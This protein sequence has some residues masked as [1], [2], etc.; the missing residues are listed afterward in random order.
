MRINNPKLISVL[1]ALII[2]TLYIYSIISY[3]ERMDVANQKIITQHAHIISDDIWRFDK[4]SAEKYLKLA[5]EANYYKNIIVTLTNSKKYLGIDTIPNHTLEKVLIRHS[6]IQTK[7]YSA[8]I[9]AGNFNIGTLS[10]TVYIRNIYY[11]FNSFLVCTTLFLIFA[12]IIYLQSSKRIL[13]RTVLDRTAELQDKEEDLRTTINSIGDAL[14]STDVTGSIN[15][16]NPVTLILLDSSNEDLLGQSI[17]DKLTLYDYNLKTKISLDVPSIIENKQID[18]IN[19]IACLSHSDH[20]PIVRVSASYVYNHNICTGLVIVIS[21]ITETKN[22][23]HKLIQSQRMESI[24]LMAGGVAHDLN[25]ILSGIVGYPELILIDLPKDSELRKPIEAIMESGKRAATVVADL[26]TVARGAASTRNIHNINSL[27]QEYL[28]SPEYKKL[29][30]LYPNIK[31]QYLPKAENHDINCSQVHI[32]KCLMNLVTNAAEVIAGEGSIFVSTYNQHIDNSISMEH[33][34]KEGEYVILT[35]QDSG[36]GISDMDLG[37]IFEPF[38]TKKVM[39]RSGTGLGLT[40]VWNTMK[41]HDGKVFVKS[42]DK[43][44][45][46]QLY[47]PVTRERSV[48]GNTNETSRAIM[49]N[50]EHILVVD[51]EPQL[52]DLASHMLQSIGYK[53]D[54]VCSGELAI[55]F[56]KENPVDLIVLDML[57][58]PGMNGH[59]TYVEVI[60]LYPKQKAIIAS[61][62][63]ASDDVKATLQLGAK[64]FIQKP[65]SMNQLTQAVK[66]AL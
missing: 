13:N 27:I 25:N 3:T 19:T 11:Y 52:R 53:V 39:G 42:S 43:G 44:T 60:K 21:D 64:D 9:I 22:L 66:E 56:I 33:D 59:Q 48:V 54:S 36:S 7:E 18:Q 17:S 61:G 58:E 40:V 46:F 14:I 57:M 45:C 26:L 2:F 49:G 31:Y 47:F 55:Q 32:K 34:L 5:I 24:G 41:D 38:Y 6:L 63:S 4:S 23:E 16:V 51:D 30:S 10:A 29:K 62:F 12:F 1:S 65:Y 15:R 37:H 35:V 50:G 28:N 8:K 20:N